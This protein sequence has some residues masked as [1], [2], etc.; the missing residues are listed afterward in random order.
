MARAGVPPL[1]P[2]LLGPAWFDLDPV[3]R[4]VHAAD[5]VI[6]ATLEI[7]HGKGLLARIVR[8]ALRVPLSTDGRK[9][10]LHIT[11]D[12]RTERWT[13]TLGG[14]SLVTVQRALPDGCLGE[15]IGPLEL[16]FRLDTAAGALA[17]VQVGAVLILGRWH[18]RLPRF[19]APRVDA[20][21]ERRDG[22]DRAHLEV[23]ISAPLVGI[24]MSYEG[25]L[26]VGAAG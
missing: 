16:R 21:E 22:G 11:S 13:R 10:T 1:Y 2:R 6:T 4:Q 12:A 26:E 9:T 19:I 15:R 17:Y 3:V 5:Q 7:R 20:R 18:V 25:C 8:A 24:L 14:R 23:R